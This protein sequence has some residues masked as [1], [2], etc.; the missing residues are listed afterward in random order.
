MQHAQRSRKC[1]KGRAAP[2][3]PPP[4]DRPTGSAPAAHSQTPTG[5]RDSAYGTV[6]SMVAGG[7]GWPRLLGGA[8]RP[9]GGHKCAQ[10]LAWHDRL[11]GLRAVHMVGWYVRV[12]R[13]SQRAGRKPAAAGRWRAGL[14]AGARGGMRRAMRRATICVA[15]WHWLT[16]GSA[17][18]PTPPPPASRCAPK[19]IH[20]DAEAQG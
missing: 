2:A 7:P 5:G 11:I 4:P 13:P 16:G 15:H 6:H 3:P 12:G 19:S 10:A 18:P 1:S 8:G 9:G 20:P 14:A 17:A